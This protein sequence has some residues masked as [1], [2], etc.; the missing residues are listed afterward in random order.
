MIEDIERE[1]EGE[2]EKSREARKA[3]SK[4]TFEMFKNRLNKEVNNG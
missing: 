2:I 3:I 1:S 4:L